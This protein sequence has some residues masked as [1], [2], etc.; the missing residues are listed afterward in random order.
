MSIKRDFYN[1]GATALEV[2]KHFLEHGELFAEDQQKRLS[3][4]KDCQCFDNGKCSEVKCPGVGC[5]CNLDTKIKFK[6]ACCPAGKW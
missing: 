4:C 6:A 2:A 5:N 1:F 3:I